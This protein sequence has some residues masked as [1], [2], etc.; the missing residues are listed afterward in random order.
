MTKTIKY[1]SEISRNVIFSESKTTTPTTPH[2][3]WGG[4]GGITVTGYLKH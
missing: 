3:S 2:R 1:M 4:G